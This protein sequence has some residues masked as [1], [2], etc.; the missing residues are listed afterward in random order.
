MAFHICDACGS[1]NSQ[2]DARQCSK[3][4]RVLCDSCKGP[5]STCKDSKHGTANCS[6]TFLRLFVHHL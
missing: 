4:R 2:G 3:C 1:K 5:L 6:G